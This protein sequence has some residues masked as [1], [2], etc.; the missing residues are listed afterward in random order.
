MSISQTFCARN[1]LL[2]QNKLVHF[3]KTACHATSYNGR[4]CTT[5]F[6]TAVSYTH[7]IFMKSATG[8]TQ[9]LA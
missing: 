6:A 9:T 5:C 1:L 8:F 7:N 2:Q 4:D 3:E